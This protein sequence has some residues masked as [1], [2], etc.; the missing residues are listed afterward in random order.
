MDKNVSRPRGGIRREWVINAFEANASLY[1]KDRESNR[2]GAISYFL[3]FLRVTTARAYLKLSCFTLRKPP[4][5]RGSRVM[6]NLNQGL[7][8]LFDVAE[9]QKQPDDIQIIIGCY[10]F[11]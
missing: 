5:Y 2:P 8:M 10:F 6:I 7:E 9:K 4:V 3:R 1:Y 11:F